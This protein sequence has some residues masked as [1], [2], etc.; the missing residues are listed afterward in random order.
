MNRSVRCTH[1]VNGMSA[2]RYAPTGVDWVIRT[3]AIGMSGGAFHSVKHLHE[4]SH[5]PRKSRSKPHAAYTLRRLRACERVRGS[6]AI[7]CMKPSVDL[8]SLVP[9]LQPATRDR[10]LERLA[11]LR[12]MTIL[13]G[14]IEGSPPLGA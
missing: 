4:R 3:A 9:P 13:F 1:P 8:E 14:C 5:H 6:H 12:L 2:E 7:P 10:E 11:V